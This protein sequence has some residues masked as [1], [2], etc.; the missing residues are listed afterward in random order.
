MRKSVPVRTSTLLLFIAA[1][2]LA[3]PAA[4]EPPGQIRFEASNLLTTAD[5]TFHDWR[6]AEAIVDDQEPGRS[7]VVVEVV[8]ASVDTAN[9]RRDEHLR[10]A[11]FFDVERF[12]VARATLEGFRLEGPDEFVADVTLDLHGVVRSFPMRFRIVDRDARRISGSV[13]LDRTQWGIGEPHSRW[14]P[15]SIRNDVELRVEA[16]VPPSS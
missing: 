6:I 14:N 4:A 12:P 15:L 13:G 3:Q 8:L 11:D 16:I 9:E 7:R 10:T 2:W 1:A 5:G